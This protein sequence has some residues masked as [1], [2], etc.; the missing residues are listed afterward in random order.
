MPFATRCVAR[1]CP[2]CAGPRSAI[3]SSRPLSTRSPKSS[4]RRHL[5]RIPQ[6]GSRLGSKPGCC[7]LGA[8]D[9]GL[10]RAV[11]P[12]TLR[13]RGRGPA[14]TQAR[15]PARPRIRLA[16]PEPSGKNLELFSVFGDGAARE[17]DPV[18]F[19]K[20]LDDLLIRVWAR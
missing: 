16:L 15:R 17:A 2:A 11:G 10:A 3:T 7:P 5:N 12:E 18:L 9:D 6:R 4:A 14:S 1:I 19:A 20:L 8:L 13:G